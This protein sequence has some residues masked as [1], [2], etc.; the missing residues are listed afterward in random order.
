MRGRRQLAEDFR[1]CSEALAALGTAEGLPRGLRLQD[2]AV[3]LQVPASGAFA[4]VCLNF[5]S[6]EAYPDS[7]VL[8]AC[9]DDPALSSKLQEVSSFYE[10]RGTLHEVL[11]HVCGEVEAGKVLSPWKR[12]PLTQGLP[13]A[14]VVLSSSLCIPL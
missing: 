11:G 6:P 13:Q 4:E 10:D 1:T 8:V 12:L 2:N 7:P 3:T 9:E 14:A 5:L